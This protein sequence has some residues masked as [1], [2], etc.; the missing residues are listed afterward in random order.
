ISRQF[1]QL[2]GGDIDLTSKVAQGSTFRFQVPVT[3]AEPPEEVAQPMIKG[4]V[5]RI[6]PHQPVYR[7][8]VVDD[9]LENRQLIEQL[10]QTVGFETQAANDGQAAIA[11]WQSWQ[12][13]LVWMDMRMPVMDGYEAAR[14]IRILEQ[15]AFG[16]RTVIIALTASAFEEQRA[17]ILAAGCDDLVRKPFR[18]QV[19]FDKLTEHL[20]VQFI[21]EKQERGENLAPSRSPLAGQPPW[22][23]I[24]ASNLTV[25]PAE[26]TATLHQA[27]TRVNAKLISELLAQIPEEHI[28]L[29]H[30]LQDL[31]DRYRFDIIVDLTQAS[32]N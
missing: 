10:L 29:A 31:V 12:P 2:M 15:Q 1:V 4:R 20:G 30:A 26:W 18:E 22:Q 21:Y 19:I 27:A 17:N 16:Q 6:A 14:Q 24:T 11:Q 23:N 5:L 28:P 25:M 32:G 7:V 3:P 13:H 9:R 8:L